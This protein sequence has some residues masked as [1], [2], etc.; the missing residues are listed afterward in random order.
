MNKATAPRFPCLAGLRGETA[1]SLAFEF[2][3][4][5]SRNKPD[6]FRIRKYRP[7]GNE[8]NTP[9]AHPA[10]SIL[11]RGLSPIF[12]PEQDP[13][14]PHGRNPLNAL[15]IKAILPRNFKH[16]CAM[17][18]Q[19]TLLPFPNN[20]AM[21]PTPLPTMKILAND[22]KRTTIMTIVFFTQ[23]DH[24]THYRSRFRDLSLRLNFRFFTL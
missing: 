1:Y 8:K 15:G 3:R 16:Q 4:F 9:P 14:K 18:L 13:P 10:P 21:L 12:L 23:I 19:G 20:S 24:Q 17:P 22:T 5:T 11:P 7:K 6:A 2:P